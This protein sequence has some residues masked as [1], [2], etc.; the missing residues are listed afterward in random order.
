MSR[1]PYW[2]M[3]KFGF[4]L[5]GGATIAS[6][7]VSEGYRFLKGGF[8]MVMETDLDENTPQDQGNDEE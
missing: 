2:E 1:N 5:G 4:L 6:I 3:A 7:V 8:K